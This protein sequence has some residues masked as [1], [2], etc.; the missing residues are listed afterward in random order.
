MSIIYKPKAIIANGRYEIIR[1]IGE[2]GTGTVYQGK[3]KQ[4]I[5]DVAIKVLRQELV[6]DSKQVEI[7]KHEAQLAAQLIHPNIVNTY[8]T[9]TDQKDG[10]TIYLL[11]MEYL[12]GGSLMAK[13]KSGISVMKSIVWIKQLLNATAYAH[14]K[15]IIHQD[16]KSANIFLTSDED[17]KIGDFGLAKLV[18]PSYSEFLNAAI[19]STVNTDLPVIK[20]TPAYMSPELCY[21]EIQDERSDIYSLGVLFFEMLTGQLPF[22]AEGTIELPGS[23]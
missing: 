7:F 10:N 5:E 8:E 16:I 13:I 1:L 3:D 11:V 19:S 23:M 4:T 17:V 9:V 15:G 22:Q 6:E 14:D 12:A 2:G 20:G 21:G 18:D